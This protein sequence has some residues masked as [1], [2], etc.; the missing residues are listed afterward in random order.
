V[1]GQEPP[2]RQPGAV[3]RPAADSPQMQGSKA[4]VLAIA[5]APLSHKHLPDGGV[6][7]ALAAA[8]LAHGG[9]KVDVQWAKGGM[10]PGLLG[11]PSIEIALPVTGADCDRPNDLAP[12]SAALCD[13]GTYSDPILQVVVGL[14][15]LSNSPFKFETDESVFGRTICIPQ[16]QDVSP[17]NGAGRNW[18]SHKRVTV[19]RQANLLEC[20]AAVQGRQAEAFLATDL[21][22]RFLLDRLGLV[23]SFRLAERALEIRGVHAV[24]SQEHA[25]GAEL[26]QSLNRGLGRLK[27]SDAYAAIVRKHLTTLGPQ[28]KASSS[29]LPKG[30]TAGPALPPFRSDREVRTAPHATVVLPAAREGALRL[31]RKGEEE[32]AQGRLVPARLLYERAAEMGLAEAAMALAA[33]YDPGELNRLDLRGGIVRADAAQAR[34]WYERARALGASEAGARLQRLEGN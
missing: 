16:D 19:L 2:A 27:Q 25:R 15:T 11:D 18:L 13:G 17:L 22:G 1:Q 5:R 10:T 26:I 28:A 9:S 29:S 32:L 8:S 24:A 12:V 33:T 4:R 34:F 30:V 14:F 20:A 23:Q 31:M 21:E 3:A 6:I 7:L